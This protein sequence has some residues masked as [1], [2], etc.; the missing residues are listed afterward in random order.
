MH[1]TAGVEARSAR[2][3]G[4]VTTEIILD[5]KSAFAGSAE[6]RGLPEISHS[7]AHYIVRLRFRVTPMAGVIPVT[8][9]ELDGDNVKRCMVM[10]TSGL[11]IKEQA[12]DLPHSA[13]P[14]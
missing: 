8:A 11:L 6:Y 5:G 12:M 7:P 13:H 10:N 14:R 1:G 2:E 3:A 4:K 9:S